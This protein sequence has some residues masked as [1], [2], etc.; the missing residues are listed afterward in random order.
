[1][2]SNGVSKLVE[3]I[4]GCGLVLPVLHL[5]SPLRDQHE[6]KDGQQEEDVKPQ[7][8]AEEDEIGDD[9]CAKLS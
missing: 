2:T 1:M 9:T 4:I 5:L 3:P 8:T 6:A 7:Q